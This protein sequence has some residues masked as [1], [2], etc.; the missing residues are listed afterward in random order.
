MK[1]QLS[2]SEKNDIYHAT[3][4]GE[5]YYKSVRQAES[6]TQ[7]YCGICEVEEVEY[8]GD[9]CEICAPTLEEEMKFSNSDSIEL[10]DESDPTATTTGEP[11]SN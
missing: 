3:G 2:I 11:L 4:G 7:N 8:R 6:G 5:S 10:L 1:K 9:L